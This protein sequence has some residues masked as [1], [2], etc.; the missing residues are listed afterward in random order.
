MFLA[1]PYY[2]TSTKWV[3]NDKKYTCVRCD[4]FICI[5]FD[6]NGRWVII[7]DFSGLDIINVIFPNP[8][9]TYITLSV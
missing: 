6:E 9:V 2:G 5:C 7:C 8:R 1:T 3:K 4:T